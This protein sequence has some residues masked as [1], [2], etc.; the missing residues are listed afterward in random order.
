MWIPGER[1]GR[2]VAVTSGLPGAELRGAQWASV[3]PS[4]IDAAE[5]HPGV[6][7]VQAALHTELMSPVVAVVERAQRRG[8]LPPGRPPVEIVA[9]L[10]GPLFYRRWFSKEPVDGEFV[11]RLLETVTGGEN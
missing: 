1:P 3:L 10:V 2:F 9:S 6:A 4:I 8:E 7:R 11:T 5:R